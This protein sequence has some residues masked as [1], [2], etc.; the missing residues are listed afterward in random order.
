MTMS[1]EGKF[2][3][4][5]VIRIYWDGQE[6][7]SVESPV[8]DFFCC[9]WGENQSIFA[10]PINTNPVGGM[11]CYFPTPFKK[12]VRITIENSSV[13]DLTHFFIK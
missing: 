9:G 7:P 5:A 8:G 12:H 1:G 10:I 3:R 2:N 11:N 4:D 6:H 13:E